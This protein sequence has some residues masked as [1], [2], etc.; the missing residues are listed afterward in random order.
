MRLLCV[1]WHPHATLSLPYVD[2][3]NTHRQ[4]TRK[5]S[6][7]VCGGAEDDGYGWFMIECTSMPSLEAIGSTNKENSSRT[8]FG[9]CQNDCD[10]CAWTA[11]P[12]PMRSDQIHVSRAFRNASVGR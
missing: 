2:M 5:G 8:R 7:D 11:W 12:A 6:S 4:V 1:P 10:T 9:Q 3:H